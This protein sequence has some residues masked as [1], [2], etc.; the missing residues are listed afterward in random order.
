MCLAVTLYT[1]LW[2]VL[3]RIYAGTPVILIRLS[4]VF[5]IPSREMPG[6]YLNYTKTA[7]FQT[8]FNSHFKYFLKLGKYCTRGSLAGDYEEYCLLE[9]AV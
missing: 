9:Q 7:S 4:V 3:G 6:Q 1:C 8:L 2:E 5:F